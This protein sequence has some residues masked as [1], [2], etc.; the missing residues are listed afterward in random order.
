[1]FALCLTCGM[2]ILLVRQHTVNTSTLYI[3]HVTTL[4]SIK[5]TVSLCGYRNFRSNLFLSLQRNNFMVII[6]QLML[7][8]EWIVS[9]FVACKGAITAM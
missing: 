1:M 3:Y 7:R 5:L 9:Q 6:L 4:A 2:F 8:K